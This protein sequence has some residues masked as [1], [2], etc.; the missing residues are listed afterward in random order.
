MTAAL[1]VALMRTERALWSA[2]GARLGSDQAHRLEVLARR[3]GEE[4]GLVECFPVALPVR[5]IGP[6]EATSGWYR[7]ND[8]HVRTLLRSRRRSI[9]CVP[10]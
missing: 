2:H 10:T 7:R 3:V 9:H 8:P 4:Q 6:P 1:V 5:P